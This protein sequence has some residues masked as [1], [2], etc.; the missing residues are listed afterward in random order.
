MEELDKKTS[1]IKTKMIPLKS[2]VITIGVIILI[3]GI[4]LFAYDYGFKKGANA[5]ASAGVNYGANALAGQMCETNQTF[6]CQNGKICGCF[7]INTGG[8]NNENI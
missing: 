3:A 4:S 6:K 5:G 8:G 1:K 2:I 7:M